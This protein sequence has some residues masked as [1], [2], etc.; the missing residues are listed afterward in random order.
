MSADDI[1]SNCV[2]YLSVSCLLHKGN[3]L[4]ED[5]TRCQKNRSRSLCR[6]WRGPR[7][8]EREAHTTTGRAGACRQEKAPKALGLK[9]WSDYLRASR[10]GPAIFRKILFTDNMT[11]K[12]YS[13]VYAF[14]RKVEHKSHLL[15]SAAGM[16]GNGSPTGRARNVGCRWPG[17]SRPCSAG[18]HG[19][20]RPGQ[21][22]RGARGIRPPMEVTP[23][24]SS[25]HRRVRRGRN[26]LDAC[27]C[28]PF[29]VPAVIIYS[30]YL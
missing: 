23:F 16:A 13:C 29:P 2:T 28:G 10:E 18:E 5:G 25:F 1:F 27:Y 20:S 11:S 8:D 15:H 26:S 17:G 9:R 7:C 21:A 6:K 22:P 19:R 4:L 30:P 14:P 24:V 12:T 3:R